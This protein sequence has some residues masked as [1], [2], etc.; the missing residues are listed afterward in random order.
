MLRHQLLEQSGNLIQSG[1]GFGQSGRFRGDI[2]VMKTKIVDGQFIHPLKGGIS[3]FL[4]HLQWISCTKALVRRTPTEHIRTF[5]AHGMPVR[6]G[7]FQ[8][9]PH[10]L[11][12]NN[13]VGI[14]IAE[15]HRICRFGTFISN[16]GNTGEILFFHN[17]SSYIILC[18]CTLQTYL[19][20]RPIVQKTVNILPLSAADQALYFVRISLRA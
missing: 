10:R 1:I 17:D 14:V 18:T 20:V 7:K 12:G 3:L 6:E 5:S 4:V 16:L 8:L 11:S 2:P 13:F 15:R 19:S 9:F